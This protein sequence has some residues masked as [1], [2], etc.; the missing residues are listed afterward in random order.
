MPLGVTKNLL[1]DC[2]RGIVIVVDAPQRASEQQPQTDVLG[3]DGG[4]EIDQRRFQQRESSWL[5]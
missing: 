5:S 4:L 2:A 3:L 1:N